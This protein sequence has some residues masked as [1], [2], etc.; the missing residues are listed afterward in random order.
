MNER[1]PCQRNILKNTGTTH[2]KIY[3][4]KKRPN[5]NIVGIEQGEQT[6][7]KGTNIF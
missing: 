1:I 6:E 5:M 4:T 3:E 7:I 2:K